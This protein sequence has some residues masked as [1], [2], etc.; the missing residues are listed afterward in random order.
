MIAAPEG[1]VAI[2]ML[3]SA[4]GIAFA[5]IPVAF[6]LG[7]VAIL[8]G[9]VFWGPQALLLVTLKASDTMNAGL[10]LAVPL[11]VFMAYML[12]TA[13][14]A[15]DLFAAQQAWFGALPGGLAAGAVVGCMLVAAMSGISTTGVL[16]MGILGVPAMLSR[17]YS[18]RL[19]MGSVMAGGALGALIPPSVVG[20]V[21]ALMA[22]VS[23]EKLFLAGILPGLMLGSLFIVYALA[24]CAIDPSL[25]PP[26]PRHERPPLAQK[27]RSLRGISLP[28]LIVIAVLGS[29]FAGF[30]T[31]TEAAAVGSAGAIAAAALNGRLNRDVI[32][33]VTDKTI[34]SVAVVMWIIFCA[35]L[36]SAY[37]DAL[38]AS[39]IARSFVLELSDNRWIVLMVM[40]AV[41]IILGCFI[42]ALS[43]LLITGPIFIPIAAALEFDMVW[44]GIV[45]IVNTELGYLTP[46]FGVNLFVMR[47]IVGKQGIG[48]GEIY[49][50][51]TPFVFLQL[52]GLLL[53]I[54]F[55][56]IALVLAS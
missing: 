22:D 3:V 10:L 8:F 38:G 35:G 12:E 30:A 11:F 37:F 51:A 15:E 17:G 23:V 1:L 18:P 2:A 5:G 21:Y 53:V 48:M 13:G 47:E 45:F 42:D 50:A 56:S 20:I 24:R 31:P 36:F 34:L 25:G 14:I 44:F 7:G 4:F 46:P 49:R 41:W 32:R 55:P 40:Q 27:I 54:A 29:I 9:L 28:L 6:A 43:I 52:L 19:A 16:L 26:V 39:E 33:R